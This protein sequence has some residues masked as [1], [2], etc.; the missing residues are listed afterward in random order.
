MSQ[1]SALRTKLRRKI[2]NPSVADVADSLLTEHINTAIDRI[3]SRYV[4]NNVRKI[5]TFPTVANES[6]YFLPNDCF[7]VL[8]VRDNTNN[9]RL[10]KIGDQQYADRLD[11]TPGKPESYL[12][13]KTWVTIVPVPDAVYTI[14]LFY[15]AM[16]VDLVNDAD[17]PVTPPAWDEG[18]VLMARHVYWDDIGDYVKAK[19]GLDTFNA[20]VQVMP[21][22]V[23]D[24]SATIDSGV[25]IPSLGGFADQQQQVKRLDFDHSDG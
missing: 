5:C 1:L 25:Q 23:D 4:F 20:W 2:G 10:V 3:T 11:D 6:Q 7:A 21:T 13:Q 14:E 9:K 17:L 15:K 24:E 8:R 22:E 16:P 18:I 12:R 19:Y